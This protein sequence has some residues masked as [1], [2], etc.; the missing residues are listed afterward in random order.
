MTST[1]VALKLPFTYLLLFAILITTAAKTII[2]VTFV[3][4]RDYI[5][6]EL[7]VEKDVA[8]SCCKG[9]CV[10]DKELAKTETSPSGPKWEAAKEITLFFSEP[11]TLS[12]YSTTVEGT[13]LSFNLRHQ[14]LLLDKRDN[15]PPSS[16]CL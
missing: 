12:F 11:I 7:C 15:P 16:C 5:A 8:N 2:W 1:F 3:I 4:H 6:K 9:S 14:H 13:Y 10:L